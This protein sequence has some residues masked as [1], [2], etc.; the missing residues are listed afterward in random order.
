[1]IIAGRARSVAAA[2]GSGP[3]PPAFPE[4]GGGSGGIVLE[5]SPSHPNETTESA[6]G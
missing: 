1:M 5:V 6:A 3:I 2:G 4:G